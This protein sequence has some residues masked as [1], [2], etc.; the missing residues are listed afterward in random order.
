MF[1]GVSGCPSGW[2]AITN[3]GFIPVFSNDATKVGRM[4]TAKAIPMNSVADGGTYTFQE[5]ANCGEATFIP[6]TRSVT[7][8]SPTALVG[9]P[10]TGSYTNVQAVCGTSSPITASSSSSQTSTAPQVSIDL[11]LEA[12]FACI[13]S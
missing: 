5:S 12:V 8:T 3:A 6:S 1:R 7:A 11:P 13:K 4:N 9:L 10:Q 2:T